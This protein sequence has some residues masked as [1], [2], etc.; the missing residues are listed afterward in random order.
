MTEAQ[1][2]LQPACV[3]NCVRSERYEWKKE[4]AESVRPRSS[5][6]RVRRILWEIVSKAAERSRR[7]VVMK[8]ESAAMRRSLVILIRAVS[9]CC[10]G[11]GRQIEF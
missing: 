10:G 4:K 9:R 1:G 8:P 2:E 7:S 3:T 11:S 5:D 6:R